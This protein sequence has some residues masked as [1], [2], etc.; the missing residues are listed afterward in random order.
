MLELDHIVS[1]YPPPLRSFRR[2]ILREY[3]QYKV[4]EIIYSSPHGPA[5]G[6]MGGTAL[7]IIHGQT[8]FSE[9]LD[10]D[11]RGLSK[12]GFEDMSEIVRKKLTLEGYQAETRLV[13]KGA[14]SCHL[15]IKHL[16]FETGLSGHER[17]K[18]LLKIDAE[19]QDF[20]YACDKTLLSRF[21]VM[22]YVHAAPSQL[23][24]A[25]KY[26]AFLGRKRTL[27]RDIYD[28][29]FL[30]GKAEPDMAYL[31]AKLD[32]K[33][34]AQLKQ[35]LLLKCETLDLKQAAKEVEPFLFNTT[36]SKK[37]L[38]FPDLVKKMDQ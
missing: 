21:D 36:D 38:Y 33:S 30:S 32:I 6:F 26:A 23:L 7:R 8:R 5:L 24:L 29:V 37:V 19:P 9:D 1:F 27:G 3:L 34:A 31:E 4:L 15:K 11:N 2:N 10:F 17:E 14:F 18:L 25:Q 20:D 13:F 12:K 22:T 35:R 28:A 16:L